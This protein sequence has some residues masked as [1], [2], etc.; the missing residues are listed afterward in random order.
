MFATCIT[1][2]LVPSLYMILED[3]KSWI[4]SGAGA[5]ELA[6]NELA[7]VATDSD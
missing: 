2:I 1:L 4:V 6:S 5:T 3:I 7:G